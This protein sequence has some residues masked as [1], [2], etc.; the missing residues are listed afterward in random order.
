LHGHFR[1]ARGLGERAIAVL[2]NECVGAV[3]EIGFIQNWLNSTLSY[4]G[5]LAELQRTTPIIIRQAL[6]RGDLYSATNFRVG[7]ATTR[8]LAS[9]EPQRLHEEAAEAIRLWSGRG[10]LFQHFYELHARCQADLYVGDGAAAYARLQ[11]RRQPLLRSAIMRMEITRVMVH[12]LMGRVGIAAAASAA[13]DEARRLRAGVRK[14]IAQLMRDSLPWGH[15]AALLL[16][17]ALAR[18]EG[19]TDETI[20]LLTTAAARAEELDMALHA[21]AAR[22]A[23]AAWTQGDDGAA[24][25]RACETWCAAQRVV[26]PPRLLQMIAPGIR[27]D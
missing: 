25:E 24:A 2:S 3:W 4:L 23:L 16:R 7:F 18:A 15:A 13:P 1:E 10:F 9:D 12:V 27:P 6:E 17:A 11:E 21:V 14:N 19:D 5:E 22:S 26:N 20:G 8:W